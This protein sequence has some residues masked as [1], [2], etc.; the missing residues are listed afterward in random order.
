MVVGPHVKTPATGSFGIPRRP[1]P[2][3]LRPPGAH[4]FRLRQPIAHTHPKSMTPRPSESHP[5]HKSNLYSTVSQEADN[6]NKKEHRAYGAFVS[7]LWLAENVKSLYVVRKKIPSHPGSTYQPS[8]HSH[9][10]FSVWSWEVWEPSRPPGGPPALVTHQ[11]HVY[12]VLIY[13]LSFRSSK[14]VSGAYSA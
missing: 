8:S 14:N 9:A 10:L 13:Q 4:S 2:G 5:P 6:K 7:F 1:A 11:N 3:G 12:H